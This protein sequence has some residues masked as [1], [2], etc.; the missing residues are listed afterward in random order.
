MSRKIDNNKQLA[1][2]E[3]PIIMNELDEIYCEREQLGCE[4]QDILRSINSFLYLFFNEHVITEDKFMQL[5][6]SRDREQPE[7]HL[8]Q[9][10]LGEYK[11]K[12]LMIP[13]GAIEDTL[14]ERR[15]AMLEFLGD[16][17]FFFVLQEIKKNDGTKTDYVFGCK[18]HGEHWYIIDSKTGVRTTRLIDFLHPRNGL[19]IPRTRP[20]LLYDLQCMQY[21]ILE[22]LKKYQI[23]TGDDIKRWIPEQKKLTDQKVELGS[24]LQDIVYTITQFV[25]MTLKTSIESRF[26]E[27]IKLWKCFQDDLQED[28]SD[29][30]TY[31]DYIP[32]LT[33]RFLQLDL[34]HV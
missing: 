15:V 18:K 6:R 29:F 7:M 1:L 2:M 16:T 13:I 8:L 3:T 9:Y 24:D 14:E 17:E 10:I 32:D 19:F 31:Q 12:G 23:Q 11:F 25:Y 4:R 22:I 27:Y 20:F 5:W 26:N 34:V 30:E 21:H 28:P 33:V